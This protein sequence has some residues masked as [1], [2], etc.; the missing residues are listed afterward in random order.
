MRTITAGG[1][2]VSIIK[3]PISPPKV[4]TGPFHSTQTSSSN[5]LPGKGTQL[6][7][8]AAAYEAMASYGKGT[9]G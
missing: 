4:K 8:T 7:G 9:G 3:K 1:P 2:I 6:G 5:N